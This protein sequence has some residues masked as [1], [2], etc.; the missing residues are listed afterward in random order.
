[1]LEEAVGIARDAG[2]VSLLPYGLLLLAL[3]LPPDD[4]GRALTLLDEA[5]E[6]GTRLGDLEGVAG[7]TS[8]QA[9]MA[10]RN[11][12]WR[13]ELRAAADGAE[14]EFRLRG[15][16]RFGLHFWQAA[17]AFVGLGYVEPA[18]VLCGLIDLPYVDSETKERAA[19]VESTLLEGL[20]EQ[21]LAVLK[22]R[23]AALDTADAVAYLRD[24][25]ERVL[26]D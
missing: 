8:I 21:Q 18:A 20:G 22:A 11:R 12:D 26:S 5:A 10:F 9:E 4:S 2:I 19:R 17:E 25:S 15:S 7:V 24:E 1:V 13:A 16:V 3:H 14:L 23:G 6:L